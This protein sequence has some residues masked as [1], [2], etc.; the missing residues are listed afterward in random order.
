MGN[1]QRLGIAKAMIYRPRILL[2]DEP[3]NGLDPA[4]IVEVCQLLKELAENQGVTV[5]I[6]SHRLDEISKLAT[7][8]GIIDKGRLIREIDGDKLKGEL[9]RSLILV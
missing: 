9:K 8:I 1:A 5:L 4:G 2:L 6:S 3:T 7:N